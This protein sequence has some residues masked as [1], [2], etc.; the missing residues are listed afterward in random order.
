[1]S[2]YELFSTILRQKYFWGGGWVLKGRFISRTTNGGVS[3][4]LDKYNE[5]Y[6]MLLIMN[7]QADDSDKI[8]SGFFNASA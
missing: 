7:M 8:S 5:K 1:M 4:A 2:E 6:I 3:R